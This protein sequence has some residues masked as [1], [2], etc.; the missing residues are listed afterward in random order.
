MIR[1]CLNACIR[2]ALSACGEGSEEPGKENV[3]VSRAAAARRRLGAMGLGPGPRGR[4]QGHADGVGATGV[5]TR[6]GA[7]PAGE[8]QGN[9]AEVLFPQAVTLA[10]KLLIP[11]VLILHLI[12]L[13][14]HK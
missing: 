14:D 9:K 13:E 12:I 2:R 10:I 11:L 4:E 8:G 1:H 5:G 3:S 7:S 6:T